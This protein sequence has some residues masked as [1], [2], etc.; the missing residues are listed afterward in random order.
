MSDPLESRVARTEVR[1]DGHDKDIARMNSQV[2]VLGKTL[3]A[4]QQNLTQIKWVI[5]G[6]VGAAAVQYLDVKDLIKILLSFV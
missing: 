3:N 4:I 1:L 2:D 6:A 5:V